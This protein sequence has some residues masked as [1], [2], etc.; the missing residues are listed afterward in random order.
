MSTIR[1]GAIATASLLALALSACSTTPTAPVAGTDEDRPAICDDV[2]LTRVGY[3]PYANSGGYFPFVEQGLIEIFEECGITVTTSDPDAD[4]GRQVSGIENLV[5][6]GA[7]AVIITPTDPLAISPLARRLQSDGVLVVGLATSIDEAD[8]TFNLDDFAFGLLEGQSAGEWLAANRQGEVPKV[9][10]LHQDSGGDP[11][12]ARH[13]GAIAGIDEVLGEGNWELVSE[14]EA[15]QEDTGN[16]QTSVI[17]QAN[18]DLDL[19]I[20]LND[21]SALGALSAIKASGRTPGV[22]VGVVTG[23]EDQRI[24][25]A[26]LAGEV[27]STIGLFPV[28]QGRIIAEAILRYSAGEEI[29]RE[30]IVPVELV[31]SANAQQI[32]D[33]I[34]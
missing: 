25:E 2:D 20:G 18:P 33:T 27:H 17:L 30:Q 26:V 4:S 3:S 31:T 14:V 22:D 10:I 8:I 19:I 9:A 32:L 5:A 24:L 16:A 13:A 12:L 15:F 34:P 28:A 23:G 29:E 1:F 21:A 7:G 6:G 11:L